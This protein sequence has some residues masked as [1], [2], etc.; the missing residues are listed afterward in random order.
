MQR[1]KGKTVGAL[2]GE[3]VLVVEDQPIV[4]RLVVMILRNNRY[5]VHEV[6]QPRR[7][8][9]AREFRDQ[10][11]LLLTDVIMPDINGPELAEQLDVICPE[12]QGA[13][14][15]RLHRR[16][17]WSPTMIRR[18]MTVSCKSRSVPSSCWRKSAARWII[19]TERWDDMCPSSI[20]KPPGNTRISKV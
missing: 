20:Q 7:L 14:Y 10:I 15:V 19:P 16:A 4:R 8:Y 11:S 9:I 1:S 13:V 3:C 18:T 6:Q 12:T 5:T 17:Q 2:P